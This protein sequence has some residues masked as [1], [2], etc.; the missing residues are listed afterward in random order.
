MEGA[1]AFVRP[2]RGT[3]LAGMS[4]APPDEGVRGSMFEFDATRSAYDK[5]LTYRS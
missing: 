4:A 3:I 1:D 5:I 2:D